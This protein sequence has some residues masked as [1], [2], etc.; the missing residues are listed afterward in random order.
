VVRLWVRL[1]YLSHIVGDLCADEADEADKD[2]LSC[3]A[4]HAALPDTHPPQPSDL[5]RTI[6]P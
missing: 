1:R 6:A 3:P 4:K 2:K 5:S